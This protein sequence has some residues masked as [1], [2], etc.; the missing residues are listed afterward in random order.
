MD[1]RD[2]DQSVLE[3]M[4]ELTQNEKVQEDIFT[5]RAAMLSF[6]TL[7]HKA[8]AHNNYD[9]RV[10]WKAVEGKYQGN[11]Q[12]KQQA[13]ARAGQN[14]DDEQN[15][16]CPVEL[17][18][19]LAQQVADKL[20]S[21]DEEERILIIKTL[22]NMGLK[23]TL[24]ELQ[25][26]AEDESTPVYIR[27]QSIYA[28]RHIA[29][30]HPEDVAE[31]LLPLYRLTK[32][33][34]QVRIAAF[35]IL[36]AGQPD[37]PLL[38]DIT[39]SLNQEPDLDVASYVYS[40]LTTLANST[41][42]CLKN[43]TRDARLAL[44]FTAPINSDW[45]HSKGLH[46]G[47]FIPA[48]KSGLF[49][50][51]N[52]IMD[53]DAPAPRAGNFRLHANVMGKSLDLFEVTFETEGFGDSLRK[54]IGN[55]S[56]ESLADVLSGKAPSRRPRD[57]QLPEDIS[58]INGLLN[59]QPREPKTPRGTASIKLF[60]QETR[61]V[62]INP[63]TVSRFLIEL[64]TQSQSVGSKLFAEGLPVDNRRA[65]LLINTRVEFP[66]VLGFPI[67]SSI[68]LPVFGGVKGNL[69][70]AME[71]KPEAGAGFFKQIP[72]KLTIESD[73][74]TQVAGELHSKVSVY[75]G[76][77][78]IGAGVRTRISLNLPLDGKLEFNL[79]ER[80]SKLTMDLPENPINLVKMQSYPVT[81]VSRFSKNEQT[82]QPKPIEQRPTQGAANQDE[83]DSA[84]Q[85]H[86]PSQRQQNPG[87]KYLKMRV[88]PVETELITENGHV[89]F[90]RLV[91]LPIVVP[92]VWEVAT[93]DFVKSRQFNLT[94]GHESMAYEI[95]VNSECEYPETRLSH[96][97]LPTLASKHELEVKMIPKQGAKKVSVTVFERTS[98]TL[99]SEKEMLAKLQDK[100][101]GL[102]VKDLAKSNTPKDFEKFPKLGH[103]LQFLFNSE[104]SDAADA[105]TTRGLLAILYSVDGRYVK[106]L[107]A[108]ESKL[109]ALAKKVCFAGELRY[110]DRNNMWFMS[111]QDTMHNKSV[112]GNMEMSW[113]EECGTEKMVKLR[114]RLQKSD[115]QRTVEKKSLYDV[116]GIPI[117]DEIAHEVTE[118]ENL[119]QPLWKQCQQDRQRGAFFSKECVD[120]AIRYSDLLRL[121]I[122]V[123]Y[124]NVSPAM[125]K[126]LHRAERMTKSCFH[127]NTDIE[128]VDIRNP[129]NKLNAEIEISTDRSQIDISY[130][131]PTQNVNMTN[132]EMPFNVQPV[133]AL[134][135]WSPARLVGLVQTP[136]C[137][138][139]GPKINTF[140]DVSDE[141]PLSGSCWHV[142]A[143]DNG[144]QDLFAVL[145][146]NVNANS[147]AKKVAVLFKGHRIEIVPKSAPG[148]S[149]PS[150]P[151]GIK[152]Y[153]VKYNGQEIPDALTAE[154]RTTI[155]PNTPQEKQ[156]VADVMLI[157]PESSGN[158]EPIVGILS[159]PTGLLVLFDGSSVTV[160]PSPFW[161][162]GV[163]GLCGP[164]SGQTWD[165]LL[166]PNNTVADNA[167]E[168]A[169]AFMLNKAGC[170]A[171]IP[172]FKNRQRS[173]RRQ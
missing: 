149:D 80:M 113:G 29:P 159:T 142:L 101:T 10:A 32:N 143:K 47:E 66:S 72:K 169:R 130:R 109:P 115:E 63:Q 21:A 164:Y 111:P 152:N 20:K 58:E 3:A 91:G 41:D 74:Q 167:E 97:W 166:L 70:V 148:T 45:R 79:Q 12:S 52:S 11:T 16:R 108:M 87:Q 19:R 5:K 28:M 128:D 154:K 99:Q 43:V 93:Q 73:L 107:G 64:M 123:E 131:T 55:V 134:F 77:I 140:D 146:A 61:F 26:V 27:T 135:P 17:R 119:F 62:V 30:V 104:G 60:G 118:G 4:F 50:E 138:L 13:E 38:E 139:S 33:P 157:K 40:S 69:K 25:L 133:S 35:V 49:W 103:S 145:V 78:K 162:G 129:E 44:E 15:L 161:K 31:I 158:K 126:I 114:L 168:Y 170:D 102:N 42:P 37:L 2:V 95:Q 68:R 14:T 51:T 155:P 23:E 46:R 1:V 96:Q 117:P 22:G 147:N 153:V 48:L 94:I 24:D 67:G 172:E 81:F 112:Q 57:A 137:T 106:T 171:T 173:E 65:L 160:M 150:Q 163:V 54:I 83:D 7:V 122:D 9:A 53:K 6:G 76:F 18:Q 34:T 136:S 88:Q 124:K 156:E 165:D 141:Q 120:F 110:P 85:Q 82:Y 39:Q 127:W 59:I 86:T 89:Q 125:R 98:F 75:L 36:L 100:L 132:L 56:A 90:K 121:K 92:E 84:E 151:I 116:N 71:P 105:W 144:P 8:C